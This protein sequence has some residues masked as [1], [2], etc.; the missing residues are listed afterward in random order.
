[1]QISSGELASEVGITRRMVNIFAQRAGLKRTRGKLDR[2][3]FLEARKKYVDPIQQSNGRKGGRPAKASA[4]PKPATPVSPQPESRLEHPATR[5]RKTDDG[6]I[7]EGQRLRVWLRAKR[8]R[9]ELERMEG[10]LV[11]RAE[12][13]AAAFERARAERD[14]LLNLPARI[15][16]IFAA[17]FGI[18][19][20]KLF[21]ALE[22]HIR[23]FLEERSGTGELL[24]AAVS[25]NGKHGS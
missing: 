11:N 6:S 25:G 10:K 16:P 21:L 15:A 18:D 7:D 4:K 1:M 9:I 12:V 8:E 13:E 17:D 3:Q 20:R 19:S 14:A 24:N 22:Q 2:E 5:P 23:Q